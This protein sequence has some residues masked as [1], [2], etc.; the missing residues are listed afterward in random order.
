[1]QMKGGEKVTLH[2]GGHVL[3]RPGRHSPRREKCERQETREIP[4]LSGQGQ[5]RTNSEDA[6]QEPLPDEIAEQIQDQHQAN[7]NRQI[8]N[9]EAAARGSEA[10]KEAAIAMQEENLSN[11]DQDGFSM[12]TGDENA[13]EPTLTEEQEEPK[14]RKLRTRF[15]KRFG[16]MVRAKNIKCRIGEDVFAKA[17]DSQFTK[18]GEVSK[19]ESSRQSTSRRTHHDIQVDE[20]I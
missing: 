3:R 5:R 17:D 2:P 4:R 12:P 16:K 20:E 18:I 13:V 7:I 15:V 8:T 1:M 6:L 19:E 14:P 9:A 10:E 11:L